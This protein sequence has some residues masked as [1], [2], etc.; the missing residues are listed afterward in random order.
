MSA[1]EQMEQ[2]FGSLATKHAREV[3]TKTETVTQPVK[4]PRKQGKGGSGSHEGGRSQGSS[5]GTDRRARPR[6]LD[7]ESLTTLLAKM[8]LRQ[9]DNTNVLRAESAMVLHMQPTTPGLLHL[10]MQAS[11]EWKKQTQAPQPTVVGKTS[12]R[13][14]L[15]QLWARELRLRLQDEDHLKHARQEGWLASDHWVYQ[16]WNAAEKKLEVA[17]QQGITHQDMITMLSSLSSDL[18]MQGVVHRFHST[19]P[20][21]A[22]QQSTLVFLLELG[23]RS[24]PAQRAVAT[25]QRLQRNAVLQVVGCQLR[26]E[27]LR[28]SPLAKRLATLLHPGRRLSPSLSLLP[29]P[30][31]PLPP[32]PFHSR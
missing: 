15:A 19:R 16:R 17:P 24:E 14:V 1:D 18:G 3:E 10:L 31:L 22:N 2:F 25:L 29:P 27:G 4:Y 13:V 9:E 12:L 30:L 8:V 5:S 21:G 32:S 20:M 11:Q 23:Y 28:R 26:P 7:E 6:A